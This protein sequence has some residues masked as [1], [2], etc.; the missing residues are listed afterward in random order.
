MEIQE[1]QEIARTNALEK[2]AAIKLPNGA[3]K[4]I[5][6][7]GANSPRAG[8][9]I[10]GAVQ[11]GLQLGALGAALGGLHGLYAGEEGHKLESTGKS[12]LKGGLIG[13]GIGA[14]AGGGAL[15]GMAHWSPDL[16]KR[17]YQ[18]RLNSL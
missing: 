14:V 18:Q 1:I 11:G 9:A 2:F 15:S 4:L 6:Q 12:A 10:E 7:L 5:V 3:N 16:F 8:A 13:S 17:E